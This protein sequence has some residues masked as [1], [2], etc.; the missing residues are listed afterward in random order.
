MDPG[1][2]ATVAKHCDLTPHDRQH[3]E[4]HHAPDPSHYYAAL[5]PLQ[6]PAATSPS[7]L[8]S[9]TPPGSPPATYPASSLAQPPG[10]LPSPLPPSSAAA[11]APSGAPSAPQTHHE[12][13][14][15]QLRELQEQLRELQQQQR[16]RTPSPHRLR[17]AN[18][19]EAPPA[20][21]ARPTSSQ[22]PPHPGT[23]Q[24]QGSMHSQGQ[25]SAKAS[26]ERQQGQ[27]QPSG[28]QGHSGPA[29]PG[30][31]PASAGQYAG[32]TEQELVAKVSGVALAGSR[33]GDYA[34][35]RRVQVY[36]Y[37][38]GDAGRAFRV[39]LHPQ[40]HVH[41]LPWTVQQDVQVNFKCPDNSAPAVILTSKA[42]VLCPNATGYG[43]AGKH[44]QARTARPA[45]RGPP[46]VAGVGGPREEPQRHPQPIRCR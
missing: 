38:Y 41:R 35:G 25:A 34:G 9:A 37:W 8:L 33:A 27:Q 32:A 4:A 36:V 18:G 6:G 3:R 19:P 22:P 5:I 2:S 31:A 46:A 15:A 39:R 13:Q 30:R 28:S 42:A 12:R 10:S 23:L 40:R 29:S 44:A 24:Q 16:S 43:A 1:G 11:P 21:A 17:T 45:A 7:R 14:M 26:L 20:P